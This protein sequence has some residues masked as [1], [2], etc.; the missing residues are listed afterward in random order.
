MILTKRMLDH[1]RETNYICSRL[2]NAQAERLLV[3]FGQE[4]APEP[5]FVWDEEP[6]WHTIR[7]MTH[8]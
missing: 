3:I 8:L 7:K 5:P 1:L 2:T 6:I 4:P